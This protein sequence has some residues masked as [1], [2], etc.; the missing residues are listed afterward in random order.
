MASFFIFIRHQFIQADS[1]CFMTI[2]SFFFC[3]RIT[4]CQQIDWFQIIR[5]FELFSDYLWNKQAY[6]QASKPLNGC[7]Q[8]HMFCQNRSI[9]ISRL[10]LVVFAYPCFIVIGAYDNI[11]RCTIK[12]RSFVQ[13][14]S[15]FFTL[16][17]KQPLRLR[18]G[19]CWCYVCC[20]QDFRQLLRL[21]LLLFV[22]AYLKSFF[23]YIK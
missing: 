9:V 17:H 11:C 1:L 4:K 20:F 14:R 22:F 10:H 6:P 15:A 7:F 16:Y 8:H 5:K 3:I 13:F 21:Y 2:R 18:I 19:S 12:A 23:H